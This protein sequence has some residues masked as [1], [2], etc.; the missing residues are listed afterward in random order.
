MPNPRI[1]PVPLKLA[2][3]HIRTIKRLEGL[4]LG[5]IVLADQTLVTVTEPE[6]HTGRAIDAPGGVRFTVVSVVA[7]KD[8]AGATLQVTLEYG[9]PW[10][11][12]A[13]RG[14]NPGGIWPE[15]LRPEAQAPELQVFDAAGKAMQ[16]E[17]QTGHLHN[18]GGQSVQLTMTMQ[19]PRAAGAPAKLV[20]TGPRPII[21]EVPFV[22]DNVPI[23]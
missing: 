3:P 23:P 4:I 21:I 13:R 12:G 10:A 22:L 20:V 1:I 15:S 14:W 16:E 2:T 11:A 7:P 9:T 6:K 19:Y 5:E 18:F 8:S 17:S